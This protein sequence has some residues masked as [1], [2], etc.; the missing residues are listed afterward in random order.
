MKMTLSLIYF[1][2][3]KHSTLWITYKKVSIL[4]NR[5]KQSPFCNT[6]IISFWLNITSIFANQ[7]YFSSTMFAAA[8]AAKSLRSCPTLCDPIGGSPPC[9]SVPGI[10][11]ARTLE[12]GWYTASHINFIRSQR[13]NWPSK[14]LLSWENIFQLRLTLFTPFQ[15]TPSEDTAL[16]IEI[17]DIPSSSKICFCKTRLSDCLISERQLSSCESE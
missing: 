17:A 4:V 1:S 15:R 2:V 7:K 10:L 8:A 13:L 11:Q 12:L 16:N 14:Y 3:C 5:T 6:F 9:F